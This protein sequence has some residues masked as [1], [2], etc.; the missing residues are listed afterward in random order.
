MSTDIMVL[1]LFV[2]LLFGGWGLAFYFLRK[3]SV[4]S[5]LWR[6]GSKSDMPGRV[7][8]V[9]EALGQA[10]SRPIE[11]S[12]LDEATQRVVNAALQQPPRT[13][14]EH[15]HGDD[16]FYVRCTNSVGTFV[17]MYVFDLQELLPHILLR[18]ARS[19]G[20]ALR[21]FVQLVSEQSL[22]WCEGI[23]D[24]DFDIFTEKGDELDG[25]AILSPEVLEKLHHPPHGATLMIKKNK[26]YYLFYGKKT[27]EKESGVV[28]THAA[29]ARTELE[30]NLRR[31]AMGPGNKEKLERIGQSPI[32][33]SNQEYFLQSEGKLFTEF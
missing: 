26:L 30:D 27:M 32:G 19:S 29:A 12:N 4:N 7:Q 28:V 13:V 5:L 9:Q 23:V 18:S 33:L 1:I 6:L 20:T 31:W 10:I 16:W 2:V 3:P 11:Q 25:L 21:F 17:T 14:A 8:E 24:R 22:V 15:M